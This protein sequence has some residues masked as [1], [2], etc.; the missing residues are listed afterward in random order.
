MDYYEKYCE[1]I[2]LKELFD[3]LIYKV[4]HD[5]RL[6]YENN[7]LII[8]FGIVDQLLLSFRLDKYE[9]TIISNKKMYKNTDI[10]ETVDGLFNI[11][12]YGTNEFTK[13]T[14]T[15]NSNVSLKTIENQLLEINYIEKIYLAELF[16]KSTNILLTKFNACN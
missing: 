13:P 11:S 12:F 5:D 7:S 4:G 8:K 6:Y 2:L 16:K 10:T 1:K 3:N 14:L 15:F 9:I